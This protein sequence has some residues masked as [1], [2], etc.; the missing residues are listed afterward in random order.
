MFLPLEFALS[1]LS[2][3]WRK[4]SSLRITERTHEKA[5]EARH[6]GREGRHSQEAF[7]VRLNSAIG[8]ITPKDML[9]GRQQ[10]IRAERDRRPETARKQRQI[11]PQKVA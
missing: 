2:W 6:A 3:K 10:K 5:T 9:A 8:Y 1:C 11:R 7:G 4:R